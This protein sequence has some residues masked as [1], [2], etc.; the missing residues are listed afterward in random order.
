VSADKAYSNR[1]IR[2]DLRRR[3]IRHCIP[4]KTDHRGHR[5][6]R[7]SAGGRPP[8]FDR[9]LYR[10]RNTVERANNKLKQFRAVATRYGKRAY[11]FLGT[12]TVASIKIRLPEA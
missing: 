8:G 2:R 10:K 11:I 3:K 1:A 6:R 12:I 9:E 7:G 4:E 5:L